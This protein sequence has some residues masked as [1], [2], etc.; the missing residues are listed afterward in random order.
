MEMLQG[1]IKNEQEVKNDIELLLN[2]ISISP[3]EMELKNRK[4]SELTNELMLTMPSRRVEEAELK[5]EREVE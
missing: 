4:K 2:Y 5:I 3:K 1:R